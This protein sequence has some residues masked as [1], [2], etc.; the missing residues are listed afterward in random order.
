MGRIGSI[1]FGSKI[2]VFL[3]AYSHWQSDRS[4]RTVVLPLRGLF[5]P[6]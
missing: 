3:I 4:A 6:Q 1:L 5:P 2:R